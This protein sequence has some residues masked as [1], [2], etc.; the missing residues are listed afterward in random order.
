[1]L[2]S[3]ILLPSSLNIMFSKFAKLDFATGKTGDWPQL[4]QLFKSR[5]PFSHLR[6]RRFSQLP[7]FPLSHLGSTITIRRG[8]FCNNSFD[9]S[10]KGS[11]ITISRFCN[12]SGT[13]NVFFFL[14]NLLNLLTFFIIFG[15]VDFYKIFLCIV[16]FES[17]LISCGLTWPSDIPINLKNSK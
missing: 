3:I 14:Q 15:L 13:Q 16:T 11:T 1:M 7:D 5:S 2:L 9:Y 12:H 4:G 8:G 6:T 10:L 17:N